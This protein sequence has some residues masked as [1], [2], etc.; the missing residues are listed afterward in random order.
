M[1]ANEN[2]G[3]FLSMFQ[4]RF[5][6]LNMLEEQCRFGGGNDSLF[7]NSMNDAFRLNKGGDSGDMN[8]NYNSRDKS[9]VSVKEFP[10]G[11]FSINHYAG[12]VGTL[13]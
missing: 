8:V 10:D 12:K 7:L 1:V 6:I 2:S 11:A 4:Q 5:N 13:V 3:K 9:G